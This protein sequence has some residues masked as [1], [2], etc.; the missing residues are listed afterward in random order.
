MGD[1]MKD[2]KDNLIVANSI[3]YILNMDTVNDT[4]N[5]TELKFKA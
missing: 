4:L 1:F 3:N 2:A 5:F